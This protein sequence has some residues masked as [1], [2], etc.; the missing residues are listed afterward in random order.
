MRS[1]HR[2][3]LFLLTLATFVAARPASA[4]TAFAG[5]D[6]LQSTVMQKGQSSFSGLGV[7]ARMTSARLVPGFDFLPSIEYWRSKTTVSTFGIETSR[8]DA[9][10][11]VDARYTFKREGWSPYA[12]VGYGVHFI[13]NKVNAPS[14]GLTDEEDSLVK[15]GIAILGGVN[16]PLTER[17]D[18]LVD[19]KYHVLSDYGQFKLSWGLAFDF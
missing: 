4:A 14:L 11:G 7:R 3:W 8:R 2:T 6:A 17:I 16:F 1:S 12:G 19:L 18:N 10:L 5:I 15:G 9:T 13:S